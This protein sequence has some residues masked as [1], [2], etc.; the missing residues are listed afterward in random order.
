[1]NNREDVHDTL[2]RGRFLPISPLRLETRGRAEYED[3]DAS[4]MSND[5][6]RT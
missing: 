2:V 4:T 5:S 6:Q 1:M 3:V